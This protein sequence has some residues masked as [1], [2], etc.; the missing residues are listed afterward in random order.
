MPTQ[1]EIRE[2]VLKERG[3]HHTKQAHKHKKLEPVKHIYVP[4][5]LKTTHM[6]YLE[7]KYGE[8]IENILASGSLSEVAKRLNHEV[9]R[10]TLSKWKARLGLRYSPDHLPD[11]K[12]CQ[13]INISCQAGVCF[14][15]AEAGLW[16]LVEVKK[17]E[18]NRR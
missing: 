16:D 10:T 1:K 13:A 15:L 8:P 4:G 6:K 17:Q 12:L 2:R 11:C 5:Y 18:L 14:I 7:T 3:L 9:D